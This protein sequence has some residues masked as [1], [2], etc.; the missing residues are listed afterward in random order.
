MTTELR[1]IKTRERGSS[2]IDGGE[3]IFFQ[4]KERRYLSNLQVMPNIDLR[5]HLK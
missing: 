5:E 2:E 3:W 4:P 1:E